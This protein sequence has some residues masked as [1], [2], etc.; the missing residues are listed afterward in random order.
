MKSTKLKIF[1]R[2][3]FICYILAALYFMLFSEAMGRNIHSENYRYNL[4]LFKEIKRYL[5]NI[6]TI[7]YWSVV[8]NLLGNVVCFIPFGIILPVTSRKFKKL[9]SVIFLMFLFSLFVELTQLL[10]KIGSFDVDDILLNVIG[11]FIGYV[12]YYFGKRK[13]KPR[14]KKKNAKKKNKTR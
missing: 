1:S 4:V 13:M 7:G 6:E 8:I 3:L 9:Y 14:K 10:F 11:A 12:I 2:I 5:Y